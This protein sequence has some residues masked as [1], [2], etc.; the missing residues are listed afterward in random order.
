MQYVFGPVPSRRLGQSLGIDTIPLKTCNWNCVYCQLGRS[1]PLRNERLEYIPHEEII[2]QVSHALDTHTSQEIDWVTF[3]GSGEPTLHAGIGNLIREVKKLTDI[4]VAVITNGSLLFQQSV[5]EALSAADTVLPSLDA[6]TPQLY[7]KVNRPHPDIPYSAYVDGLIAFREEFKSTLWIE[8]MLVQGLNDTETELKNIANTLAEIRPEKIH[9][10]LPTRPPAEDWV[11]PPDHEG[12]IRA[13]AILGDAAPVAPLTDGSFA[14][15]PAQEVV[16][17]VI[18]IISRHPMSENQLLQ[19]LVDF[20][21]KVSA[22]IL[23]DLRN[24]N[25]V[26]FIERFGKRFLCASTSVY[27]DSEMTP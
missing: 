8:V 16:D 26:Q 21:S 23:S 19:S 2:A 27:A 22:G 17:R 20:P 25:Q 6:G 11:K 3:V 18:S 14:L 24:S 5:R 7:K 4:P 12:I 10:G 1:K 9:I 13:I 15:G